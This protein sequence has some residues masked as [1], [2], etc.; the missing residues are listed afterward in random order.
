MAAGTARRT[1]RKPPFI[2]NPWLR[3]G[4]FVLVLLYLYWM[5]STL[6]FNWERIVQGFPRAVRI[7]GG[8]FPPDFSRS[9]LLFSGLLES[10]QIAIVATLLGVLISIPVAIMA[11]RNVAPL[12]VYALGRSLII[13]ARSFHPVIVAIIFV[14]AVGFGPLAGIL[15]L[16]LYSLGFVGKLLAEAVEEISKGQVE[17]IQATG[18][19]YFKTL[20][21]A[22]FPQ[23]LPRQVGLS[24]YQ[25]D[26]NLRASAVVGIV[27]AGGIGGTLMNAFRRFDY[28][29][30]FAILVVI[31]AIILVSE[32]VSGR[33]RR[34][35]T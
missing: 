1:W 34:S 20:L 10:I 3:Y 31:I 5:I 30:A 9:Q 24:I 28:D 7:F 12:P 16:T 14:K 25:L 26:S 17:A 21:Y 4:L 11:A 15:T 22:V 6:P 13:V 29:F 2:R 27:G 23:I 8:A 18:A 19:G 33:L 35:L 32:G